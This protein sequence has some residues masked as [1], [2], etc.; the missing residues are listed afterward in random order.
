MPAPLISITKHPVDFLKEFNRDNNCK[1]REFFTTVK[2]KIVVILYYNTEQP[3]KVV[4]KV[5]EEHAVKGLR[6]ARLGLDS[7]QGQEISPFLFL[8]LFLVG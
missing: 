6:A 7:L 5:S 4:I 1:R 8:L 2:I 3:R